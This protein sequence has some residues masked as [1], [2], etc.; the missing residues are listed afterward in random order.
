[1]PNPFSVLGITPK[2]IREMNNKQISELV[3]SNYRT[4]A[5]IYH[6]DH[7]PRGA[8]RMVAITEAYKELEDQDSLSFRHYKDEYLKVTKSEQEIL[9][10]ENEISVLKEKASSSGKSIPHLLTQ[11]MLIASRLQT[12]SIFD[13]RNCFIP[14]S[15]Y[16]MSQNRN[17]IA[18]AGAGRKK[19]KPGE[20][21]EH[22]YEK[23][24]RFE[25][26]I[27]KEGRVFHHLWSG[28]V[29][30]FS[31]KKLVAKISH[32]QGFSARKILELLDCDNEI[33]TIKDLEKKMAQNALLGSR[34]GFFKET[35]YFDNRIKLKNIINI[36]DH[37]SFDVP[38][39]G[40]LLL[41]LN[42]SGGG[43][44]YL[45]LEGFLRADITY[46]FHK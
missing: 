32:K 43:E 46:D 14:M 26:I 42:L 39:K 22:F 33:F 38:K 27:D 40:D 4:L 11:C 23:E 31:D 41:S 36:C 19:R 2:I 9:R 21:A 45:S 13:L 44:Y 15:D 25:I 3:K 10:L 29:R 5:K 30:E 28:A 18:D 17:T 1:M 34:P 20:T 12:D 6:P 8:K 7:N 24:T 37:V 16:V 35:R